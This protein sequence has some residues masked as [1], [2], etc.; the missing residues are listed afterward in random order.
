MSGERITKFCACFVSNSLTLD[1]MS[2]DSVRCRQKL[3]PTYPLE[4][5]QDL[6]NQK[7]EKKKEKSKIKNS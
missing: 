7:E 2:F 4:L 3:P 6:L 1:K 5:L